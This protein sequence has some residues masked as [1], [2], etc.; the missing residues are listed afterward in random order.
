MEVPGPNAGAWWK[1]S[2]VRVAA[3]VCVIILGIA[4]LSKWSESDRQYSS[5]FM[6]KVRLLIEQA[7]QYNGLAQQDSNPTL[8]LIHCTMALNTAQIARAL[9]PE[10]HIEQITGLS[11]NEL[12]DYLED[13]QAFAIKNVGRTCP[14]IKIE[15]VYSVGTGWL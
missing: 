7:T 9:V 12:I 3:S 10:K 11:V 4:L 13:C 8:Q 14:S 1:Q 6:R 2:Q 15:G 5:T